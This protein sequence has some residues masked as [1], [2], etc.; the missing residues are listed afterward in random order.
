[1]IKVLGQVRWDFIQLLDFLSFSHATSNLLSV[2]HVPSEN[3]SVQMA[4]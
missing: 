1:M 4:D 3:G 2:H